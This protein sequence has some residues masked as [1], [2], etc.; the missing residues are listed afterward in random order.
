MGPGEP[1]DRRFIHRTIKEEMFGN[2][3]FATSYRWDHLDKTYLW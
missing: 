1:K 3:I 2:Y